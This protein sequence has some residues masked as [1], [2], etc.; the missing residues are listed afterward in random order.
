MEGMAS[1]RT[2]VE[3]EE[4]ERGNGGDGK[5][6]NRCGVGGGGREYGWGRNGRE[7]QGRAEGDYGKKSRY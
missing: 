5:R 6:S 3:V 7:G 1:G 4:G 2:A